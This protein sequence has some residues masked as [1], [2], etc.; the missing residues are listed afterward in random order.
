MFQLCLT[1][2]CFH[3]SFVNFDCELLI[4]KSYLWEFFQAESKG[5][6]LRICIC[7]CQGCVGDTTV[8]G[9]TTLNK[10][11]SMKLLNRNL[12][13]GQLMV[14]N[15]KGDTVRAVVARQPLTST[16]APRLRIRFR[17]RPLG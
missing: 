14:V 16:V 12:G 6:F 1:L 10:I 4:L 15:V 13:E 5:R 9:L 17:C 3:F 2:A 11:I 7:F 8:L